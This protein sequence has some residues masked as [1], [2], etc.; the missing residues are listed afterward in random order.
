MYGFTYYFVRVDTSCLKIFD[1]RIRSRNLIGLGEFAIALLLP[2]TFVAKNLLNSYSTRV[3][4]VITRQ[5]LFNFDD[6]LIERCPVM[7]IL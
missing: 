7:E 2:S 3:R 6:F 4:E 1:I 5:H